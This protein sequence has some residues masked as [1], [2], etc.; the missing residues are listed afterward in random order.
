MVV[1]RSIGSVHLNTI[2]RFIIKLIIYLHVWS[3]T[4][5]NYNFERTHSPGGVVIFGSQDVYLP[6][7]YA[8]AC[9]T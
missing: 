9:G 6:S 1:K 7:Q 4:L 3:A 2:T 8:C 5:P